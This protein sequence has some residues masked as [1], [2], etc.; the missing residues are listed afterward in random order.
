[1]R[2]DRARK[3]TNQ[4]RA[5]VGDRPISFS[6][7]EGAKFVDLADHLDLLGKRH[8]SEAASDT[9]RSCHAVDPDQCAV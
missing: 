7:S 3:W 6:P 4:V 1:M 8:I 5:L 9:L 2:T